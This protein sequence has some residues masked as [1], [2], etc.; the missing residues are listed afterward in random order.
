M[1]T[2]TGRIVTMVVAAAIGLAVGVVVAWAASV[3]FAP[4][5][6]VAAGVVGGYL[7]TAILK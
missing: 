3:F 6:G 2:T 7:L 1:L 5:I 4:A